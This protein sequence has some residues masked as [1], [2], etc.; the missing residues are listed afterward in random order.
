VIPHIPSTFA[1]AMRHLPRTFRP[2]APARGSTRVH[3]STVGPEPGNWMVTVRGR[4]CFV[5]E[6]SLARTNLR[7]HISSD[8]AL[9]IIR[10]EMDG[11][12]AYAEG[13]LVADGET[14][15]LGEFNSWFGEATPER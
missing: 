7:I 5:E 6:G 9:A 1:E 14:G 11:V 3:I 10:G 13:L 4:E 2:S 12:R 15:I 8:V